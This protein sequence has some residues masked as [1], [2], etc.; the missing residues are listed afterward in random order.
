M[1]RALAASAGCSARR[2]PLLA[3]CR[4]AAPGGPRRG[5]PGLGREPRPDRAGAVGSG[6]DTSRR[7][8]LFDAARPGSR[9]GGP[10]VH[11]AAVKS[12]AR[13]LALP[14][15]AGRPRASFW[16]SGTEP[17]TRG[18]RQACRRRSR[19]QRIRAGRMEPAAAAQCAERG[20]SGDR[21]G[22]R[23]EGHAAPSTAR[24]ARPGST[25]LPATW[26]AAAGG[27]VRYRLTTTGDTGYFATEPGLT[28]DYQLCRTDRP[29]AV[30]CRPVPP[31]GGRPG[32]RTRRA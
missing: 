30:S 16:P 21:H 15:Q 1:R 27:V 3:A 7:G 6:P 10:R 20:G 17:P 8:G 28:W 12:P 24:L 31:T 29:P 22:E 4:Q 13:Q 5:S 18:R 9:C 25:N 19:T 32:C 26:L 23:R 14:D 11:A 2:P